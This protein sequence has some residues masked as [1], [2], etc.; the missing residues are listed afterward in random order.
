MKK[1]C[2][3]TYNHNLYVLLSLKNLSL[4]IGILRQNLCVNDKYDAWLRWNVLHNYKRWFLEEVDVLSKR[5]GR[6]PQNVFNYSQVAYI[7]PQI[8]R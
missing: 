3:T 5:V 8:P 2:I 6:T 1:L 7:M 4:T